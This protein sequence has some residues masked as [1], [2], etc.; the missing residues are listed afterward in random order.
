MAFPRL[1][2]APEPAQDALSERTDDEL[3]ELAR[4]GLRS[5]FAVLVERH[6]RRLVNL[7]SRF[8]NDAQL[9]REL[10]QDSWVLVWQA[11]EKYRAEAGGGFVPWLV[12]VARNHCRN[13]LRRR[14]VVASHR[15]EELDEGAPQSAGQLEKLLVEERRRRV[16]GALEEL[17]FPLREALLLRYAEELRYDEIAGVVGTGESTLR[18]RVHHGLKALKAKLAEES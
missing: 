14:K 17:A 12:T 9:G 8:V 10:A 15:R 7:C 13:E 4:A 18:S 16:R 2:R 11:R 3:M 1:V 5:A 6:A